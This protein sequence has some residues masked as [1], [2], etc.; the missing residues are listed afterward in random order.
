MG[1]DIETLEKWKNPTGNFL[2]NSL[3]ESRENPTEDMLI[4]CKRLETIWSKNH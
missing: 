3:K 1:T 2:K 4:V